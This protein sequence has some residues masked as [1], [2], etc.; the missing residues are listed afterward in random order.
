ML[1]IRNNWW[2]YTLAA[3]A[4]VMIGC[5]LAAAGVTL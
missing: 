5:T 1:G 3:I 2:I 4:G